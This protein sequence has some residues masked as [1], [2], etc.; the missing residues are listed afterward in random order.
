M[1]VGAWLSGIGRWHNPCEPQCSHLLNGD[2]DNA[3]EVDSHHRVGDR[4]IL[5]HRILP[6]V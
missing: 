3:C 6:A 1:P 2:N 5:P 4:S